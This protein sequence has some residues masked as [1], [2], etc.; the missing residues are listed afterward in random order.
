MRVPGHRVV[1][2]ALTISALGF[3][4][5]A[6]GSEPRRDANE[7]TGNFPVDVSVAS[8]PSRQRLADTSDLRLKVEN[9]GKE[10][11]PQLAVTTYT[12]DTKAERPFD[13][14][15]EQP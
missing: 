13:E 3:A 14:R 2:A 6:C 9:T 8:F 7:P 11:V 15:S 1:A 4:L 5:A 12:G 10:T